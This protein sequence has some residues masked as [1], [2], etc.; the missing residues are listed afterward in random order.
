M[1]EL[2]DWLRG[3]EHLACNAYYQAATLPWE[4]DETVAW[5]KT[6]AEEEAWHFHVLGSAKTF[7]ESE[8]LTISV[9]FELGDD[10]KSKIEE[11]LLE[12]SRLVREQSPK[13]S[14]ILEL[15]AQAETSECNHLFLFVIN[16]MKA[17]STTFQCIA[18]HMQHHRDTVADHLEALGGISYETIEKLRDLPR[19][20][21][22]R[23]LVIDDS[24]AIREFLSSILSD[25]GRVDVAE[26][27]VAALNAFENHHFDAVVSDI[28]MPR[29][30][31]IEFFERASKLDD[32]LHHRFL[33][34]SACSALDEMSFINE[35]HLR[36]IEKP[37][38][39][40]TIIDSVAQLVEEGKATAKP[41]PSL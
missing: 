36:F 25:L 33:F 5:L 20:W 19:L 22:N 3:I 34:F 15:I 4:K 30:D 10:T 35:H 29:M 8:G 28:S 37:A 41:K 9:P 2:L 13:Q 21:E 31:G 32:T 14:T 7:L 6:I 1:Q 17:Y 11:P 38:R 12:I 18:S 16:T 40:R 39:I 27:G 24:P 26:D 23:I